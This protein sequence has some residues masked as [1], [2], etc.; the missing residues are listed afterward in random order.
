VL[1]LML[2]L[3][4][5]LVLMTCLWLMLMV[6]VVLSRKSLVSLAEVLFVLCTNALQI[7]FHGSCAAAF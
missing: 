3:V 2:M 1:V 5:M 7:R 6:L 4:L